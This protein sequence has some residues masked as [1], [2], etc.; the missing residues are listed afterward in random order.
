MTTRKRKIRK[1]GKLVYGWGINDS[2][3]DVN[4]MVN[5]KRKICPI[6]R[7]WVHILERCFSEKFYKKSPTYIGCTVTESWK[8]FSDF[9]RWVEN[10]DWI[11][12]EPDK[13]LLYRGNKHYSEDTVVLIERAINNF[14]SLPTKGDNLIGAYFQKENKSKPWRASLVGKLIGYFS[15]ELEAHKAWQAKKHEYACQLAD[16]Q[17]DPRV[18]KALRERYA[19]D[20]DWTNK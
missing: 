1:S 18:A 4:P 13:D 6:Y 20:K 11:G 3:Y 2:D 5:G 7:M 10:Q 14:L 15:T 9:K 12:K 16:L 8:Y 17:T 19:P